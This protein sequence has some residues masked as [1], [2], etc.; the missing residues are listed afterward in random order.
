MSCLVGHPPPPLVFCGGL[1]LAFHG[2][3][4]SGNTNRERARVQKRYVLCVLLCCGVVWCVQVEAASARRGVG[5]VKVRLG[6]VL[7]GS[8]GWL[9]GGVFCLLVLQ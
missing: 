6:C 7:W 9:V 3:W 5:L 8:V 1:S 4:Q 2:R